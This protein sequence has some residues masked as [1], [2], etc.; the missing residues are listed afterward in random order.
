MDMYT[1][2]GQN[3]YTRYSKTFRVEWFILVE[4]E[5]SYDARGVGLG[6]DF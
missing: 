1:Y 4:L 6:T 3:T 2:T 5:Y